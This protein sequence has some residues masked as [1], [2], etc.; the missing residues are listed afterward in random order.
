MEEVRGC[1]SRGTG[2]STCPLIEKEAVAVLGCSFL[3]PEGECSLSLC[4]ALGSISINKGMEKE[5]ERR[6]G[7]KETE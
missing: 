2:S 4:E 6:E 5:E 3:Q 7:G 1:K